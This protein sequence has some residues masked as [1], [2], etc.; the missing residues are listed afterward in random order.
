[1]V[2]QSDQ[3]LVGVFIK[4]NISSQCKSSF[5]ILLDSLMSY[6]TWAIKMLDS[7]SKIPEG[8]MY[9]TINSFGQYDE[10]LDTVVYD[11]TDDPTTE[12]QF[13][14]QYCALNVRP[15]KPNSYDPNY[16]AQELPKAR[17]FRK[18]MSQ[19]TPAEMS[20]VLQI[21]QN[22][23]GYCVPSTCTMTDVTRMSD[24]LNS[25]FRINSTIAWCETKEKL[26]KVDMLQLTIITLLIL[27]ILVT[28]VTS[29][30]DYKF[31]NYF[32]EKL[33]LK[34]QTNKVKLFLLS[35]SF[36]RNYKKIASF[37]SFEERFS[38]IYGIRFLTHLWVMYAH[39]Y[40]IQNFM[41]VGN[42]IKLRR[43]P[44]EF[45][46]QF[47]TNGSLAAETF[48]FMSGFVVALVMS[49]D[50]IQS[51]TT[52]SNGT[53][54]QHPFSGNKKMK[55]KVFLQRWTRY[56]VELY[57][58]RVWRYL[59]VLLMAIGIA[60]IWPVT[61]SGPIWTETLTFFSNNC[62]QNWLATLF[63]YSNFKQ[64]DEMCLVHS[65]YT[66]LDTQLYLFAPFITFVLI[67]R[68]KIGVAFT[69]TMI[70]IGIIGTATET[71][72][73]RY[74]P[75]PIFQIQ[76]IDYVRVLR[77]WVYKL[78]FRP[79]LHLA[80][81]AIGILTAVYLSKHPKVILHDV[82]IHTGWIIS[83][84]VKFGILFAVYPWNKGESIP[85]VTISALY[86]SLSRPLWSLSLSFDVICGASY[87]SGLLTTLLSWNFFKPL[88]RLT[89]T[90]YL[91]HPLIMMATAA[92]NRAPYHFTH[93]LMFQRFCSFV[94]MTY[95]T[96]LAVHLVLEGPLIVIERNFGLWKGHKRH[97]NESS[98]EEK[99][100]RRLSTSTTTTIDNFVY[101]DKSTT[102]N[103]IG[104]CL[105]ESSHS[106]ALPPV[107][108]VL[109][110]PSDENFGVNSIT[111]FTHINNN[112]NNNSNNNCNNNNCNNN[113]NKRQVEQ[114]S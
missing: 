97:S 27:L 49:R 78:F 102:N 17:I 23:F 55:H 93:F 106:I 50:L 47:F 16:L 33:L 35:F 68:P 1:M 39:T 90:A 72:I 10:C 77:D 58:V 32:D 82:I 71:V 89:F 37:D 73:N 11:V 26:A 101:S 110:R 4:Y 67:K 25:R 21:A 105:V 30:I 29:Y 114:K 14:G 43:I 103:G 74:P 12:V 92:S 54:D 22:R 18:M 111:S 95:F 38:F 48:F 6:E 113:I 85:T 44:Q 2:G 59:P 98:K 87:G 100:S 80:S 84:A 46:F 63:F 96:A 79:I 53:S 5:T 76:S 65:W 107:R 3:S 45:L 57:A 108:S 88:A 40:A 34:S 86:A 24:F 91:F 66:S 60:I 61:G 41:S 42:T 7:S 13:K 99:N 28:L 8:I 70:T 112:S 104:T 83:G 69:L 56:V 15:Q 109:R 81:Y 9:G 36:K 75:V 19:F 64:P 31:P 62:R 94:I 20:I 52:S 51:D